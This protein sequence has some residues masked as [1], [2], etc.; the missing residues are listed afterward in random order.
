VSCVNILSLFGY[1]EM[2]NDMSNLPAEDLS[3]IGKPLG[4]AKEFLTQGKV[5]QAKSI[6][7]KDWHYR[8]KYYD[9][10]NNNYMNTPET[11]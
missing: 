10:T 7:K 1:F 2:K 11:Y 4:H 6:L 5:S 3:A 9:E 8:S